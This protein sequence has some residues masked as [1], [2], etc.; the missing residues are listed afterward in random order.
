[1]RGTI[2]TVLTAVGCATIAALPAPPASATVRSGIGLAAPSSMSN[3]TVGCRYEAR[4]KVDDAAT[5]VKLLEA[6]AGSEG[7]MVVATTIPAADSAVLV[8]TP[9]KA[10]RRTLWA[11]QPTG[12]REVYTRPLT[13]TVSTGIIAGPLCFGS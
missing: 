10:G 3:Y 12:G 1:M 8:W 11:V 5:V 13:V 7:R 9:T 6:P 2:A 4:V